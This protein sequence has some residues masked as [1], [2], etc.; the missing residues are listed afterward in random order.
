MEL[1]LL[2][3]FL[4]KIR[5]E[6]DRKVREAIEI[7]NKIKEKLKIKTAIKKFEKKLKNSYL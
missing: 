1:L 5:F 6:I 4:N 7:G 3:R 2:T